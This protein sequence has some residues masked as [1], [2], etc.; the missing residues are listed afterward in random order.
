MKPSLMA[1][2]LTPTSLA[3]NAGVGAEGPR[4]GAVGAAAV[5]VAPPPALGLVA[6]AVTVGATVVDVESAA[7]PAWSVVSV[8]PPALGVEPAPAVN[9]FPDA[10]VVF[11]LVIGFPNA[12]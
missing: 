11:A 8:E 3:V 4:A 1:V 12:S 9:A 2:G 5:E 10:T 6:A 7:L